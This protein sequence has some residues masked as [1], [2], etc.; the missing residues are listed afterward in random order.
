M[1]TRGASTY[2]KDW[3]MNSQASTADQLE[4]AQ[5]FILAEN[6]STEDRA[7]KI[8]AALICEARGLYDAADYYRT[9]AWWDL[10]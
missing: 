9:K 7:G 4:Q 6:V 2:S 5:P 8:V 1:T 3:R 10:P